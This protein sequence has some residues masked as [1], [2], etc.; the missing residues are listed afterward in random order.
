MT[1]TDALETDDLHVSF[2]LSDS[3]SS[4][5]RG[6]VVSLDQTATYDFSASATYRI[7]ISRANF[8]WE[9]IV[10]AS[11]SISFIGVYDPQTFGTAYERVIRYAPDGFLTRSTN[12]DGDVT[13]LANY[14]DNA[15]YFRESNAFNSIILL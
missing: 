5:S 2:D 1:D 15:Y 12:I 10:N 4:S 8:E 7:R 11:T 3:A 6:E 9:D 14:V 13:E